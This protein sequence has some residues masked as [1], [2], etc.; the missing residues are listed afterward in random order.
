MSELPELLKLVRV[1]V[2]KAER[3]LKNAEHTLTPGDD[4]PFDDVFFALQGR[5]GG[6]VPVCLRWNVLGWIGPTRTRR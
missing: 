4:C 5:R 6:I 3:D 2:E 1:W